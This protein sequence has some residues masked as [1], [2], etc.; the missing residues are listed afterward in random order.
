MFQGVGD[1]RYF[2]A[3]V[4][5]NNPNRDTEL[6]DRALAV[7]FSN[8]GLTF[9]TYDK[10]EENGMV[11][12]DVPLNHREGDW[13]YLYFQYHHAEEKAF[14]FVQYPE[15]E[16]IVVEIPASHY[17]AGYLKFTVGG[18]DNN[19]RSFNGQISGIQYFVDEHVVTNV[20]DFHTFVYSCNPPPQDDLC[21][22]VLNHE[23]NDG[24]V[25]EANP[26]TPYDSEKTVE[27]ALDVF[28]PE[29]SVSGWF[30]WSPMENQ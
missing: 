11:F 20:E 4:S 8:L 6:G 18:S 21:T 9:S 16:T 19:Y 5:E 14:A 30:K 24:V 1:E 13:G 27:N 29:Y 10:E 26:N 25:E 17:E 23:Y 15:E 12:A 22:E 28:A 7:F 2:L 3:R